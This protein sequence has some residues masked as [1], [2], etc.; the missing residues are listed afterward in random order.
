MNRIPLCVT[1]FSL[2][3]GLS[4]EDLS[5]KTKYTTPDA[6][7]AIGNGSVYSFCQDGEGAVWMNTN[8][9]LC[10]FNGN[11]LDYVYDNVPYNNMCGN[12]A[13]YIYVPAQSSILRFET[14]SQEPVALK[15]RP[16]ILR[17]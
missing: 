8:Y 16:T 7:R 1:L 17:L 13:R 10:R 4:L 2:L 3:L 6:L 9:G 12:G 11:T 15:A 5:A 14:G